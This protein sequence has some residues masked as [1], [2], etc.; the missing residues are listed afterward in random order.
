METTEGAP[1]DFVQENMKV[2]TTFSRHVNR[3]TNPV[4]GDEKRA[5][6]SKLSCIERCPAQPQ[7]WRCT[8]VPQGKNGAEDNGGDVDFDP[9]YDGDNELSSTTTNL[10]P[11]NDAGNTGKW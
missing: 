2:W 10:D 6:W 11:F 4:A 8:Q 9:G 7:G 3:K 1:R 5:D